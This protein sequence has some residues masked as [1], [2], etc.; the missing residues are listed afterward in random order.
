MAGSNLFF[1]FALPSMTSGQRAVAPYLYA[2]VSK[3]RF[4]AG[5]R[6]RIFFGVTDECELLGG[7]WHLHCDDTIAGFQVQASGGWSLAAFPRT[8]SHPPVSMRKAAG[9]RTI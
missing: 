5:G 3:L 9:P 7:A 6:S 2:V 8:R 1:Y 4:Q